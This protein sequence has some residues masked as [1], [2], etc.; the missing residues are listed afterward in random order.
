MFNGDGVGRQVEVVHIE[1]FVN[2]ALNERVVGCVVVGAGLKSVISTCR[3]AFCTEDMANVFVHFGI[4]GS[5]EETK[6]F[7]I[8]RADRNF[9]VHAF[10]VSGNRDFFL[11]KA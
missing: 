2:E 5:S 4:F 9:H 10:D 8:L 6:K 11:A 7:P 1:I 3:R